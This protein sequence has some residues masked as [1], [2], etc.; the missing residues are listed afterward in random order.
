MFVSSPYG[1]T[2]IQLDRPVITLDISEVSNT[3]PESIEKEKDFF[4]QFYKAG[5]ESML[6]QV[7]QA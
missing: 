7:N 3:P 4:D 2:K 6:T 5:Q 1:D